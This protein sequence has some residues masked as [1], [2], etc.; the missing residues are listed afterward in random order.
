MD[1]CGGRGRGRWGLVLL[2][3]HLERDKGGEI[4]VWS[5]WHGVKEIIIKYN[6]GQHEHNSARSGVEVTGFIQTH[7]I[8]LR[9]VQPTFVTHLSY[10]TSLPPSSIPAVRH[11]PIAQNPIHPLNSSSPLSPQS[12]RHNLPLKP[13]P[14]IP[15][16]PSFL[17]SQLSPARQSRI[18]IPIRRI[19]QPHIL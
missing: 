17:Q 1:S 14:I 10:H 18:P 11:Q 7:T 3:W 2:R 6:R 5:D 16:P 13:L 9:L 15:L 19:Y 8:A 4:I 12:C